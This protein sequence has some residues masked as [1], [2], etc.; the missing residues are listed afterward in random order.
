VYRQEKLSINDL[1]SIS[2]VKHQKTQ[3]NLTLQNGSREF[4][5]L[6]LYFYIDIKTLKRPTPT[7]RQSVL[8]KIILKISFEKIFGG[9]ELQYRD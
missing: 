1:Q 3:L 8:P 4:D 5:N 7:G 6:Y 2:K 9:T